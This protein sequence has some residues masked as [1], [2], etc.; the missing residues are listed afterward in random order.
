MKRII[1][2]P[3]HHLSV[4]GHHTVSDTPS[5]PRDAIRSPDRIS[6]FKPTIAGLGAPAKTFVFP[7]EPGKVAMIPSIT[8]SPRV[9]SSGATLFDVTFSMRLITGETHEFNIFLPPLSVSRSID[10]DAIQRQS[11]DRTRED[12]IYADRNA[13]LGLQRTGTAYLVAVTYPAFSQ[14]LAR[15]ATIDMNN[16]FCTDDYAD[17]NTSA[18]S[19]HIA[20]STNRTIELLTRLSRLP[21]HRSDALATALDQFTTPLDTPQNLAYARAFI[22]QI[23][24]LAPLGIIPRESLGSLR[25]YFRAVRTEKDHE[26]TGRIPSEGVNKLIRADASGAYHAIEKGAEFLGVDFLSIERKYSPILDLK[27][28]VANCV[29]YSNDVYSLTKEHLVFV[30][31]L[32]TDEGGDLTRQAGRTADIKRHG[33]TDPDLLSRLRSV[34]AFSLPHIKWQTGATPDLVTAIRASIDEHNVLMN[35]YF[36]LKMTLETDINSEATHLEAS[37]AIQSGEAQAASR[38]LL[39]ELREDHAQI[40]TYYTVFEGWLAH[41][42]WAFSVPRYNL[43][44][45]ECDHDRLIQLVGAQESLGTGTL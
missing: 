29:E 36:S 1:S 42:W 44:I 7:T 28:L 11:L 41:G 5:S 34:V 23:A 30:D 27:R 35:D 8:F 21:D 38:D 19:T 26:E 24:L 15:Q 32:L 40:Q 18:T 2:V 16:L 17:G 39:R 12:G 45:T 43:G 6:E 20:E 33:L 10:Y 37:I 14:A 31:K 4:V 9:L 25:S 22:D 3:D 13:I